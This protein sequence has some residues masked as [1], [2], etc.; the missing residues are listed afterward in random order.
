MFCEFKVNNIINKL[1][2]SIVSN[3]K[4]FNILY[5]KRMYFFCLP[6]PKGLAMTHKKKSNKV[7]LS[8]VIALCAMTPQ[9]GNV[10]V[11]L[12][13]SLALHVIASHPGAWQSKNAIHPNNYY[14]FKS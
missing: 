13:A 9:L 3:F 1:I 14:I 12:A 6:R 4:I 7:P 5:T 2:F 11:N 8:I 10:Q